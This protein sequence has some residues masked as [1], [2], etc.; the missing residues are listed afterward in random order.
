M[1]GYLQRGSKPIS[2]VVNLYRG[3]P[4]NIAVSQEREIPSS[5][6]RRN[7]GERNYR[8]FVHPGVHMRE[9]RRLVSVLRV[10]E[11]SS[12]E[13]QTG[14]PR[15]RNSYSRVGDSDWGNPHNGGFG[16]P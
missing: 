14:D 3:Y 1:I 15:G 4:I 5:E 7:P 12:M 9:A 16:L 11:I 2:G 8:E 10:G 13:H 6:Y